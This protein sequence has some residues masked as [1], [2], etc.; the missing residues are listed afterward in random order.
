M[1]T[2][3]WGNRRERKV[4]E[5]PAVGI[6]QTVGH[7]GQWAEGQPTCSHPH[8][9]SSQ[10]ATCS[11]PQPQPLSSP[12]SGF[13]HCT[14][15]LLSSLQESELF[16]V[17]TLMAFFLCLPSL[18][19]HAMAHTPCSWNTQLLTG[20]SG[21]PC[22]EASWRP[23]GPATGCV[24]QAEAWPSRQELSKFLWLPLRDKVTANSAGSEP[25]FT[26]GLCM[27]RQSPHVSDTGAGGYK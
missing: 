16:Y 5:P 3:A 24:W 1:Q 25:G 15:S 7:G 22:R 13:L 6:L 27:D 12:G 18:P 9:S 14:P 4:A 21:P 26:C 19:L 8:L 23:P 10:S 2:S 11:P 20:T 17:P